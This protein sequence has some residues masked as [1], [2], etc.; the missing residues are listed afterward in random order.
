MNADRPKLLVLTPTLGR[1][2]YLDGSVAAVR[3]LTLDV[4][5]ILVCPADRVGELQGRFPGCRVVPDAGREGGIYGALNAGLAAAANDPTWQWFTYINDDDLLA[6]PG[7]P[8]LVRRHCHGGL[9]ENAATVAYGDIVNIDA[10][11]RPLGRMTVE[12]NPAHLG[13]LLQGGIS[14]VGQQG[15]LF[16]RPVV[17]ALGGYSLSHKL[18]GD[19]DFWARAH[20]AGFSFTYY[21]LEVGRF[22]IQAGQLSGDV[23]L[24]RREL[25]A[26]TAACFPVPASG[27][28]K[29]VARLRYRL[30]N[31]PR[32]LERLRAV[33][34]ATSEQVL[35]GGGRPVA[36]VAT[37]P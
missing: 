7:F 12:P 19:L 21:P 6:V 30:F 9:P 14:P 1:S 5:H 31:A 27:W 37:T 3:S 2:E 33:G 8:E 10:A 18:C 34:F 20:A 36:A 17:E 23:A 25:E 22:R 35:A 11:G 32:Y 15:M 13:T 4:T 16:G 26:I 28:A 29:A 24:T